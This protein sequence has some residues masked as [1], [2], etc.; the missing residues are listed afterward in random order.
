MLAVPD[1]YALSTLDASLG[2][3]RQRKERVFLEEEVGGE[4]KLSCCFLG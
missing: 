1:R 3:Q 2:S 4:V